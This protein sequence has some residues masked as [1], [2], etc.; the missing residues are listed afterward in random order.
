MSSFISILESRDPELAFQ[1]CLDAFEQ[2]QKHSDAFALTFS[3]R[4][5]YLPGAPLVDL[6]ALFALHRKSDGSHRVGLGLA[7]ASPELLA[8]LGATDASWEAL[9]AW[10]RRQQLIWLDLSQPLTLKPVKIPKPWG[11]EIWYTGIEERGQ[12]EVTDNA[13]RSVPLP[14]LLATLPRYLTGTDGQQLV[15]LKVLDPL[16]EPV[17]GDLYFEMHEEKREVYVVTHVDAQA[18]PDGRGG[19]RFGFD[20]HRRREAG[21]DQEF[22]A[23]Y[24]E[25]VRAYRSVRVRIDELLD[26]RRLEQGIGLNDPLEPELLKGWL[27]ELPAALRSEEAELRAAM[28]S[29]IHVDP[30]QLGDV[31]KVPCFTPHS[32]LHGVRT[33]EFQTPVYERKIL[34]FAQKVLTQSHWD[35]E[36]AMELVSLDSP[37]PAKLPLIAED[38]NHRVEEVVVFED[39]RVERISLRSGAHYDLVAGAEYAL[40]MAVTDGLQLNHHAL[41]A[42][43]AVLLPAGDAA[44]SLSFSGAGDGVVL[45]ARPQQEG[46]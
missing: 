5:D 37:E 1:Q 2:S 40:V 32:L 25:A 29:F 35:T 7:Q 3:A 10:C 9:E 24:L 19:I 34:S 46:R 43:Q 14:W 15:L 6:L 22:K 45:L 28:E 13:G 30:L 36:E 12:S 23:R 39:F 44:L 17:F 33:V 27:R 38:D 18:W 21:S 42:E 8:G 31:V 4:Q 20:Q 11:Q 16:P 26:Q 41:E